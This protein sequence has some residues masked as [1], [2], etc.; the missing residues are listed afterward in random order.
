MEA[1]RFVFKLPARSALLIGMLSAGLIAHTIFLVNEKLQS[2][3]ILGNWF[4]WVVFGAWGLSFA[5]LVLTIRSPDRGI[6]LF[7]IPIILCLIGV[8]Q[9]VR[10]FDPF[11]GEATVPVWRMV[12]GVSLMLGTMFIS[13]GFAFGLMY[14]VQSNRLKNRKRQKGVLKLPALEFVRSM[15]RLGLIAT[16][17]SLAIGLIS[18][19]ALNSQR[20]V[21]VWADSGVIFTFLLFALSV[22]AAAIELS[23][24]SSLGGRRSA[25]LSI[26]IFF[27]LALVLALVFMTSHANKTESEESSASIGWE[28]VL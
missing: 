28:V 1:S 26:A 25:Y 9:I 15:N 10:P 13:F 3:V 6:G 22:S 19:I 2:G 23:D 11:G 18:G 24:R 12:H 4:E 27:F 21:P 20:E 5:C 17:V 14:L 7:L 8:A 16:A